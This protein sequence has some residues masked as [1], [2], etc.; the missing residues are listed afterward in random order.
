MKNRLY[1]L[2]TIV[3]ISL[4]TTALAQDFNTGSQLMNTGST[5]SSQVYG[6]GATAVDPVYGSTSNGVIS[7]GLGGVT[8]DDEERSDQSP[9]GA[10][11]IMLLFAA[12]SG[13]VVAL[14][15]RNKKN[16]LA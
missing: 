5:Y 10:P 4:T 16:A 15:R 6:V 9:I 1:I 8:E 11:Y 12:A 13:A 7:R 14:R 3:A 2:S